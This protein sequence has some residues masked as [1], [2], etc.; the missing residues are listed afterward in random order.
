MIT[1]GREILQMFIAG[2]KLGRQEV[3]DSSETIDHF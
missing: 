2:N 1:A 3:R